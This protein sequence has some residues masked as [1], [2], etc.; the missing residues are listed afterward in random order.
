M[1]LK[2]DRTRREAIQLLATEV[3]VLS[4]ESLLLGEALSSSVPSTSS[5]ESLGG[6]WSFSFDE[7][8]EGIAN[9]W[10]TRDLS[11]RIKLPG[12]TDLAGRALLSPIQRSTQ[13][14][15]RRSWPASVSE[16]I[17]SYAGS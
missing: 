1:A 17:A 9:R 2:F 10:F 14:A 15:A 6:E 7:N 16:V 8:N 11:D 13:P 12:S 3:S 5:G 4:I